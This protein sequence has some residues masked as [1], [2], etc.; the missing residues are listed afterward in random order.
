[1]LIYGYAGGCG[2][3]IM[4]ITLYLNIMHL[5]NLSEINP[6]FLIKTFLRPIF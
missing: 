2:A 3:Y 6:I 5:M 4:N 1:M